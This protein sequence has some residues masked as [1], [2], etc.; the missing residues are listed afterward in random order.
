MFA[1]SQ[2]QFADCQLML[3]SPMLIPLADACTKSA[4]EYLSL[5]LD[6]ARAANK[7]APAVTD[8]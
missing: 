3:L 2:S 6:L 4:L 8:T 5:A 7:A 1:I